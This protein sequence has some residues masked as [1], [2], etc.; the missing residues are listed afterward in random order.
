MRSITVLGL[1]LTV[2]QVQGSQIR[3]LVVGTKNNPS[4]SLSLRGL[5]GTSRVWD[6]IYNRPFGVP[7]VFDLDD[8]FSAGTT[9]FQTGIYLVPGGVYTVE[10]RA[11]L[12]TDTDGTTCSIVVGERS[13]T[14][15][16]GTISGTGV[17]GVVTAG[18][19]QPVQST[20]FFDAM[21]I[22]SPDFYSTGPNGENYIDWKLHFQAHGTGEIIVSRAV[23]IGLTG[24]T[25][26]FEQ[27]VL[28]VTR[29][30]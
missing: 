25:L 28:G 3:A 4:P 13:I 2:L 6:D 12:V 20:S 14:N 10:Y 29:W 1:L 8:D 30:K 26:G 27:Q 18:N 22:A 16:P 17:W 23:N 7:V 5:A 24:V 11:R 15:P 21:I 19:G 9:S